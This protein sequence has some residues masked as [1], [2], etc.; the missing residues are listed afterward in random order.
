MEIENIVANTVLLKAREGESRGARRRGR[1]S[2]SSRRGGLSAEE[3]G[4]E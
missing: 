3:K 1:R 4:L 2:G